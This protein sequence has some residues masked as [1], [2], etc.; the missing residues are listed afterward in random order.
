VTDEIKIRVFFS[1]SDERE[2]M[3][4]IKVLKSK[5]EAPRFRI[6]LQ[7]T[8]KGMK[9]EISAK[10]VVAARTAVNAL[11]RNYKIICDLKDL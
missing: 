8:R 2:V 3:R 9:A 11:L 7:P 4:I 6:D 1:I 10:D 5:E